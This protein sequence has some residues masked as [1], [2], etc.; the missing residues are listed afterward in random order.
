MEEQNLNES[1][2]EQPVAPK[3]S[4]NEESKTL[5][6]ETNSQQTASSGQQTAASGQQS[7]DSSMQPAAE[8]LAVESTDDETAKEP[9]TVFVEPEVDYSAMGREELVATLE[10]LL[11]DEDITHVKNRVSALKMRFNDLEKEHYDAEFA[12]FI[13]DGGNK[14]DYKRQEDQTSEAYGKLYATY[15]RR[16]QEHLD[17]VEAEKQQNLTAK[18]AVLES[19]KQLVER[20]EENMRKANDEFKELQERW[21]QIGEVPRDKMNDLWQQYHFLIEQFFNK[22]RINRELRDLDMKRNLEQKVQLCEKAEE[23]IVETSMEKAFKALQDLRRRWK[24]TGPVP[25][26]Q[27]EEIWQRFCNAMNKIEERRKEYYEQRKEELEKNHLAKQAL[28]EKAEELTA[29]PMESTK[30]WNDTSA[31][32]DGLLK[33]WKAIGPV[34]REVNEEIWSKFKGIIDR[35]YEQKKEHFGQLRD[36]QNNNYNKKI[37]LCLKAEAI[38]KRDD[39]RKAT[40]ELLQLQKEWKEIG[41][42][43]RKVSEKI[44]HRFRGACDEFFKRKTEY[45]NSIHGSEQ[46]NLQKKEAII[47]QLKAFEFGESKEENLRVIKDFQRQW[48]EIG[49]VPIADKER[50][51]KEFR[52][53]ID[54]HFEKLKISAIE[55]EENN[56]RMRLKSIGGDVKKFV[57]G[58]REE[59]MTKIEKLK[60]EISLWDNNLGF[61]SNSRQADLL[62]EEFEKKMQH[63][64]QQIALLEAKLKILRESEKEGGSQK[65][66]ENKDDK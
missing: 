53:V 66:E 59:I 24:E 21:K 54:E 31:E 23:L 51:Q 45:F 4:D 20:G 27:N 43:S 39:W 18:E 22:M 12:K 15:R 47:E 58:E 34:P 50:L 26:E 55:A 42:V 62:K 44:W 25:V 28:I 35:H 19:L 56:Y 10:E 33:M 1:A 2:M 17:A 48:M 57:N 9:E 61:F 63:T 49:Y 38:A 16:R 52:R 8:T 37:D 3:P 60:G 7:E 29:K 32:L 64:R 40:D 11:K 41:P 6:N 65:T 14:D 46:E 36:E 30:D 5:A 13:S